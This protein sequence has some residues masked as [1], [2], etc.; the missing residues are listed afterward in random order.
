M[1]V[2][3]SH[4]FF[5]TLCAFYSAAFSFHT[6]RRDDQFHLCDTA[7]E[8]R[9]LKN[10]RGRGRL[11]RE[12]LPEKKHRKVWQNDMKEWGIMLE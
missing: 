2:L 8:R 7:A 4:K 1:R 6:V 5:P 11:E 9:G 12:I 10:K 3:S